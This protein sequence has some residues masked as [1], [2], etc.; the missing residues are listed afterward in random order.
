V[1]IV[2]LRG[3]DSYLGTLHHDQLPNFKLYPD[4]NTWPQNTK[5]TSQLRSNTRKSVVPEPQC[6]RV[7]TPTS[8]APCQRQHPMTEPRPQLPRT[9]TNR[10]PQPHGKPLT[11]RRHR[12]LLSV[13]MLPPHDQ[14][15]CLV[16]TACKM[17]CTMPSRE[18][19]TYPALH[20][21]LKT[22]LRD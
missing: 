21:L 18:T 1:F 16:N 9:S 4:T 2:H 5:S 8:Q 6:G 22:L 13:H 14:R 11:M 20:L 19:P 17:T 7:T 12:S 10:F 15:L 3:N